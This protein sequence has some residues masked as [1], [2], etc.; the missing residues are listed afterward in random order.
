MDA[1]A[2]LRKDG[3]YDLN[4]RVFGPDGALRREFLLGDGIQDV[5]TTAEGDIWVSRFDEGV[6]GNLG[7]GGRGD[8]PP[9]SVRL[10]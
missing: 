5:Q 7:W 4:G 1:R 9:R 8:D 2:E 3:T 6:Y 10:G